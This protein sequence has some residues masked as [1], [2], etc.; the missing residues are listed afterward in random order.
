[1]KNKKS[2]CRHGYWH[3]SRVV[4]VLDGIEMETNKLYK[5][6]QVVPDI[7]V[8]TDATFGRKGRV[9]PQRTHPF[10]GCTNPVM[11][12]S[13]RSNCDVQLFDRVVHHETLNELK[14]LLEQGE[15]QLVLD[16]LLEALGALYADAHNA[17]FYSTSY[18]TKS[19]PTMEPIFE[20]MAVATTCA[21]ESH[22]YRV[23]IPAKSVRTP[24]E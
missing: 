11:Q 21:S 9:K 4:I 2:I 18:S 22:P 8:E 17:A 7:S 24:S 14:N 10:E 12:C 6:K 13:M 19:G 5:G 16:T 15:E 1:M 20:K 23:R 3:I